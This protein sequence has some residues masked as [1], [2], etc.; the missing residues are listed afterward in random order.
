MTT[1]PALPEPLIIC[2]ERFCE[3]MARHGDAVTA[4]RA[5]F[6][7]PTLSLR[8]SKRQ[9]DALKARQDIADRVTVIGESARAL[10]SVNIAT[11][12]TH[13]WNLATADPNEVIQHRRGCCRYCHGVDYSYQWTPAEYADVSARMIDAG[14]DPPM[15]PGGF[16]YD[17]TRGPDIDCPECNGE[18][19]GEMYLAD[20]RYLSERGK[21]L[22]ESMEMTKSGPKVVM[23]N[24]MDA[25]NNIAK[26][27]G[28]F[29][30]RIKVEDLT[31]PRNERDVTDLGALETP[32]LVAVFR[33]MVER[34]RSGK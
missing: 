31:R 20:S 17:K 13:W 34:Q 7:V 6:A 1:L 5:A 19:V 21:L 18:G 30:E 8:E 27:L 23:S 14:K 24:R 33:E 29:T 22:I 15:V 32:E 3:E 11:V 28:M 12:L 25:L 16:G 9:G 26:F 4:Y 2:E 10:T